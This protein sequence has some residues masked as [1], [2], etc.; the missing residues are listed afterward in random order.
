MTVCGREEVIRWELI[1][2]EVC[3][4]GDESPKF[5]HLLIISKTV[6]HCTIKLYVP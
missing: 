2:V 4:V 6:T 3:M 5:G 1:V